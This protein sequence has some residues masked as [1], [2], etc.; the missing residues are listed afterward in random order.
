MIRRPPRSTLF[1]YTTLFRSKKQ[2]YVDAMAA[3][4]VKITDVDELIALKIQGVTPEYI[5]EMH[6]LGLQP[7]TKELVGMRVQGITPEYVRE[8]RKFDSNVGVDEL[9][10][11]K[12]QGI[13]TEYISEMRKYYPNL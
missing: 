3:A 9:I 8:M 13:T 12:V 6:D 11:M 2:S 4:G 5:K 1:P 10:G 7:S